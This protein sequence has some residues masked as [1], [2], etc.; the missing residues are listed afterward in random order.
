MLWDYW[1]WLNAASDF[2][3]PPAGVH[4][5]GG[6]SA[7]KRISCVFLCYMNRGPLV[8]R[9]GGSLEGWRGLLL[10]I[11]LSASTTWLLQ[12]DRACLTA[13]CQ[14]LEKKR[15]LPS[16]SVAIWTARSAGN[17]RVMAAAAIS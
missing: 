10:V 16:V 2:P 6:F 8:L 3:L 1:S 4:L 13:V 14:I 17:F 15:C 5:F 11:Y 12:G 9:L 7:S